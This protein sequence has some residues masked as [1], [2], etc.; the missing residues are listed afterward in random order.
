MR[1]KQV[2]M[3][4]YSIGPSFV[5][6]GLVMLL[7]SLRLFSEAD[8]PPTQEAVRVTTIDGL[9]GL[10]ALGVVLHHLA[11]YHGYLISGVW[12]APPSHFY[13]SLGPFSVG[14]FFM[15][16]GYL[17]WGKLIAEEG[18]PDWL[19]LYIGRVF[20]IGPL[21]LFAALLMLVAVFVKTGL[22]NHVGWGRLGA[23]IGQWMALGFV[24]GPD[25]NG[26]FQTRYL[27]AGVT[28]SIRDEWLFYLSLMVTAL[29]TRRRNTH[30]PFALIGL[31][32]VLTVLHFH[33]FTVSAEGKV[34]HLA[35]F[36]MGMTCGS[37]NAL[38]WTARFPDRVS[39]GLVVLLVVGTFLLKNP[40]GA[41]PLV[42]DGV[43]FY[44]IISGCSLFGLLVSRPARRLG[45]VSYGIYLLQG[46]ILAAMLRPAF[47]RRLDAL[48]PAAHWGLAFLCV[49]VLV[50]FA[51]ATH[52]YIELPGVWLGKRVNKAFARVVQRRIQPKTVLQHSG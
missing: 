18:R 9:R 49:G 19:K 13:S 47:P 17:F 14:V 32:A 26:Y 24:V 12:K 31:L 38:R 41:V 30:L 39:S 22:V 7:T 36:L 16:T 42:L 33:H 20:R 23:Q 5:I 52:A 43:L 10:V 8:V 25:V 28:W 3:S 21:Y 50:V 37:L 44:L 27:L 1:E 48:N 34:A 46:L 2:R 35:L 51:T 6:I 4:F 40:Y 15:I 45:D 11:L 29:A